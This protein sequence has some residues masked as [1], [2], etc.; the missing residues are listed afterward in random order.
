MQP[1]V[2]SPLQ[3]TIASLAGR[4]ILDMRLDLSAQA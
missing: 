2:I 3:V 4:K 1:A